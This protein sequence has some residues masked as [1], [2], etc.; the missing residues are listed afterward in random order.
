MNMYEYA[1]KIMHSLFVIYSILFYL[2]L[3]CL[4]LREAIGPT[5]NSNQPRKKFHPHNKPTFGAL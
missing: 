1:T 3:K 2:Y 4:S 5:L